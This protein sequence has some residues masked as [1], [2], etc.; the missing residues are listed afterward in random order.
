[1]LAWEQPE[2]PQPQPSPLECFLN[3]FTDTNIIAPIT[4]API[5]NVAIVTPPL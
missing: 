4:T 5:K 3:C 2:Q 1:L